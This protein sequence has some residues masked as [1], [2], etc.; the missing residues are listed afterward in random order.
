MQ[1]RP[2]DRVLL[3]TLPPAEEVLSMAAQLEAGLLVGVLE[4]NEVYEARRA[5]REFSN[6]MITPAE[7]DGTLPWRE[8]FFSVVYAPHVAEPSAEMFRVLAPGGTAWVS[9]GPVTRR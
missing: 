5:L 9:R 8:G 4:R 3:L 7:A 1:L 6:V 2:D